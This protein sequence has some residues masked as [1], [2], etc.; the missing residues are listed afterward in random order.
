MDAEDALRSLGK[1]VRLSY[2]GSVC[3]KQLFEGPLEQ[4][5]WMLKTHSAPSVSFVG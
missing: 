3:T 5:E 4:L 2:V 1:L